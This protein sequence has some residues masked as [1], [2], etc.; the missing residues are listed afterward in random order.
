MKT[1]K[2]LVPIVFA[3]ALL[4][5]CGGGGGSAGLKSSDVAVVGN[6]HIT[7]E[8]FAALLQEAKQS[9][10][11]QQPPK[12]FPKQGTSAYESVK[13]QAMNILVQTAEREDK[14]ASQGITISQ[15]AID[16]RLA[17]IKKQYFGSSEAKYKAQLK[18]QHLTD[19]QVRQDVQTQLLSEAVSAKVTKDVTVSKAD[20]DKYYKAHLSNYTK[21]ETRDVRHILVKTAALA[22]TIYAKLKAGNDQTWCTLA[23]KYSGDP[24]SKDN[25]GKLT[26]SKGQTVAVFDKV[27]FSQKT[28]VIH[29]PV[30]N[31]QYGWFVIE[32]LAPIQASSTTP[33]SQVAATIKQQLLTTKKNQAMTNWVNGLS[34]DF[35]S[36]SKIKYAVG[37]KPSAAQDPCTSTSTASTT[38]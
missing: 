33:E 5:G 27:A 23:K 17:Q 25:C 8:A 24:S 19:A 30:H 21:A 4:A 35:C 11:D 38:T 18:K 3:A 29:A 22:N 37:Y 7:K 13:G 1:A 9:Y 36:G 10:A 34:K 32:P 15:S 12:A 31:A 20:V 2:F 6:Q 16:K 28:N 26:V 14:A